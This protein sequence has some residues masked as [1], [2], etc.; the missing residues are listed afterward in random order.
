MDKQTEMKSR[1]YTDNRQCKIHTAENVI[2]GVASY[3]GIVI[4]RQPHEF[5]SQTFLAGESLYTM[6]HTLQDSQHHTIKHRIKLQ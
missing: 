3:G 5:G 6:V 1:S 2:V 4:V